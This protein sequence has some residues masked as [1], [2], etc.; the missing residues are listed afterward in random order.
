LLFEV[1]EE[2]ERERAATRRG[3]RGHLASKARLESYERYMKFRELVETEAPRRQAP[4][5]SATQIWRNRDDIYRFYGYRCLNCGKVQYPHQRLC[6]ACQTKD[7]FE[8]LRL[9]DRQAEV[10]TFTV[11]FLNADA[12]PP[13]VM[14]VVDFAGGGRA[15]LQMT[16]RNPADVRIGQPVEMTFRRMYEA[17]GFTNY[18]WKCRPI[19]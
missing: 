6:I 2:I 7:Q 3:V 9:A 16:D 17:E 18:Y 19:R 15:Y 10:F 1:T 4:S 14:T 11:D 12:D 13:T 5:A 8:S